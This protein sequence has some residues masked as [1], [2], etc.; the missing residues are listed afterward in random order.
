MEHVKSAKPAKVD[1]GLPPRDVALRILSRVLND[2]EPLD[3]A[4]AAEIAA[5]GEIAGPSRAW[6]QDVTSGVLRWKGRLDLIIDSIAIK[7]KPTGWLRRVLLIA[8]YQLVAQE[9]TSPASVVFETVDLIRRKEGDAPSR[10]A[11]A[12]LRKVTSHVERWRAMPLKES[13]SSEDAARWASLPEWI[14]RK[15]EKQRGREWAEAYARASLERPS[16]WVRLK[17][18]PGPPL[19]APEW[20]SEAG[21]VPGSYR[22]TEGGAVT[23]KPGFAEGFFF[24]QDISSQLLIDE[25][26]SEV[27]ARLGEGPLTVLD[28]CAAP[29]GKSAGLAWSGFEVT[30]SDRDSGRMAL[31]RQTAE[32]LALSGTRIRIIEPAQVGSVIEQD[33]VWVDA[34]CTGTGILRRHPDVRWLRREVELKALIENQQQILKKAWEQVRSG[35]FL[36]YSV[37]SVLGEEGPGAIERAGLGPFEVRRWALEPQT[38]P[39]GDGFWCV[40]LK[41]P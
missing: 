29:G 2:H 21:P 27:R 17:E 15:L 13:A 36:A 33:L 5:K 1:K 14:W 35:G 38:V 20:A 9:R 18:F 8:V 4:F 12:L 30:S 22:V 11:N 3:E 16:I 32:R 25:V 23:G 34:P 7:K 6:L 10:F 37:C 41:K 31:L 26:T 24:V 40:L 19:S 39:N 28:V